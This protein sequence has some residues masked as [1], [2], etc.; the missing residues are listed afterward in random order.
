M[1][2]TTLSKQYM[3]YVATIYASNI[4]ALAVSYS[5]L[6][7]HVRKAA[8]V[9][10]CVSFPAC[11]CLESRIFVYPAGTGNFSFEIEIVHLKMQ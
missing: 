2:Q 9:I 8:A 5:R 4:Y 3:L 6:E 1:F 11:K 10:S 7:L